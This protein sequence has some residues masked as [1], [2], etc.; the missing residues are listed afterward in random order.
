M[1]LKSIVGGDDD[2]ARELAVSFLET[3]PGCLTRI[4]AAIAC[5]DGGSLAAEA[6]GLK[7]ISLTIGADEL[8]A[9]CRALER[10]GEDSDFL[11]IDAKAIHVGRTWNKLRAELE[12]LVNS[13]QS[14]V[15]ARSGGLD[16]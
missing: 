4:G 7:G 15:L 14:R 5:A 11:E 8:A 9:S 12:A 10:A 3:A 2:F 6:H 16:S 1:R 13:G